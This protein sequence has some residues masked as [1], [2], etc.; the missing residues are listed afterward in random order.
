[1]T[2]ERPDPFR[3]TEPTRAEL[4]S[5]LG[6]PGYVERMEFGIGAWLLY[7]DAAPGLRTSPKG[8]A[9]RSGQSRLKAGLESARDALAQLDAALQADGG[10]VAE[11]LAEHMALRGA[12]GPYQI[13]PSRENWQHALLDFLET[14]TVDGKLPHERTIAA[15]RSSIESLRSLDWDG[16]PKETLR[17]DL[18]LLVVSE[19]HVCG[20]PLGTSRDGSETTAETALRTILT[21]VKREAQDLA[22]PENLHGLILAARERLKAAS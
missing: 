10:L 9:G 6:A 21:E 20:V 7:R 1:M 13:D 16:R 14:K 3:F 2:N 12:F 22:I 8:K 18:V 4:T 19:L 15:M 11:A 5:L 17:D